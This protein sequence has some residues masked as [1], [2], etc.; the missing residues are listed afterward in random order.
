M[1]MEYPRLRLVHLLVFY[2]IELLAR[3]ARSALLPNVTSFF[4]N[5]LAHPVLLTE[6]NLDHF[7]FVIFNR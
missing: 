5:D 2:L 6:V 3:K 4:P 1:L 7:G